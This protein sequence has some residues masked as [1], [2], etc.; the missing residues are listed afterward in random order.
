M[1][2]YTRNGRGITSEVVQS[3]LESRTGTTEEVFLE[4]RCKCEKVF[5][6]ETALLAG[7]IQGMHGCYCDREHGFC[8]L[9]QILT[10]LLQAV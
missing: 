10:I 2:N 1:D 3:K 9:F 7:S 6:K 8:S 5:V 4:L